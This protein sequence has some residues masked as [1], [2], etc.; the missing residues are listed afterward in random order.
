VTKR[1]EAFDALRK[2]INAPFH[3]QKSDQEIDE[4][5]DAIGAPAESSLDAATAP[6]VN[7]AVAAEAASKAFAGHDN[8]V[9]SLQHSDAA[10]LKAF[11][12]FSLVLR[13]VL[14]ALAAGQLVDASE[15][16]NSR[17]TLLSLLNQ[18][19]LS[20]SAHLLQKYLKADLPLLLAALSSAKT[21]TT[22]LRAMAVKHASLFDAASDAVL[23]KINDAGKPFWEVGV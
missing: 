19:Q 23:S 16:E 9:S 13:A 18:S 3:S 7:R 6:T 15:L 4:V 12:H 21:V 14:D 5:F 10:L 20:S 2:N 1:K 11:E 22:K 17:K 8:S